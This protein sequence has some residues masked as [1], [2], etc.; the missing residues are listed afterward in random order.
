MAID[1]E[2][3]NSLKIDRGDE[4][5]DTASPRRWLWIGLVLALVAASAAAFLWPRT[6]EVT[7]ALAQ[8]S[9]GKGGPAAVLNASGYVTARRQAT[10]SSK[11]T[12][13]VTEVHV[14]EGM[15][16]EEGQVLARLD[17]TQIRTQLALAEAQ[18]AAAET[19]RRE[20]AVRL[21]EAK[22]NLRRTRDLSGQGIR[23]VADLD[24][25]QA[26]VD[27]LAARLEAEGSNV[28]VA[29]REV[30]V[31]RQQVED[32][33]I[34]APFAGIAISKNAQPGEM[35]S[36]VSAGGGF[37]RTGISTVVDM[38]SLEIEVD[39]NEAYIQ[40]VTPA[41][42]VTAVLDAYPEWQIPAHVITTIPAADR[43]KATV[44]VRVGFDALDP[45][46]LPDMGVKVAFLGAPEAATPADAARA[47]Q[48]PRA[49]LRGGAGEEHV[50]VVGAEERLERR[51]VRLAPGSGDPAEI[52]AGL[53]AGERVVIAGPADLVAGQRVRPVS[54]KP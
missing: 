44:K 53:T 19:A 32:H 14:E 21:D 39:V 8:A 28:E 35:I 30:A 54:P 18:L 3:L 45:R 24:A 25:A 4:R 50:L 5:G 40:R 31:V 49:A 9:S 22:L 16:V 17:D 33:A 20:T 47:T 2:A 43:Q 48:V 1:R 26:G 38:A 10:V 23:S 41:Q 42:R 36:P 11:V 27:S 29:R 7:V 12:G 13:K 6:P 34:R 15:R 51:A 46:I 52:A 37:T